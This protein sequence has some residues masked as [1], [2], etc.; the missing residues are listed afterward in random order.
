MKGEL[1]SLKA[2]SRMGDLDSGHDSGIFS[3]LLRS[4]G[5]QERVVKYTHALHGSDGIYWNAYLS[6]QQRSLVWVSCSIFDRTV[7]PHCSCQRWSASLTAAWVQSLPHCALYV[8]KPRQ[9][10]LSP[11]SVALVTSGITC[12]QPHLWWLL[13]GR[14]IANDAL[15]SPAETIT[16]TVRSQ[17][18]EHMEHL[19]CRD[20]SPVYMRIQSIRCRLYVIVIFCSPTSLPFI[21]GFRLYTV[22]F[23]GS[24]LY[25]HHIALSNS[26]LDHARMI[27][28]LPSW[29]LCTDLCKCSIQDTKK[30]I[31]FE[32]RFH[33]LSRQTRWNGCQS[34]VF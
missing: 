4:S 8:W 10:S 32:H 23:I 27:F 16:T 19:F 18:I 12:W 1:G 9:S 25:Y 21:Q 5:V 3:R 31:R 20:R 2:S 29:I 33:L 6:W 22:P 30:K 26:C 34:S 13:E 11:I 24:S 28:S 7:W 14:R 17:W 15:G